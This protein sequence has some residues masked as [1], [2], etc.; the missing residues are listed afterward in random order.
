MS[1]THARTAPLGP[2][3][4]LLERLIGTLMEL[5]ELSAGISMAPKLRLVMRPILARMVRDLEAGHGALF[6]FRPQDRHFELLISEAAPDKAPRL[7]L[8]EALERYWSAEDA[9]PF[10][11]RSSGLSD[12]QRAFV[13]AHQAELVGFPQGL[14]IPLSVR[15]QVFGL[16]MLGDKTSGFPYSPLELNVLTVLARQIA[17]GL[18]NRAQQTEHALARTELLRY[19]E[20]LQTLHSSLKAS[21]IHD[22]LVKEAVALANARQGIMYI[23]DE[24][25][26]E[27]E[28]TQAFPSRSAAG[29]M[30]DRHPL[31]GHMLESVVRHRQPRLLSAGE[32]GGLDAGSA[33]AVPLLVRRG[34]SRDSAAD[35]DRAEM[36]VAGVLCVFDKEIGR[37]VGAF[38]DADLDALASIAVTGGAAVQN[39]RLYEQATRDG[40]TRL[41]IRHYFE[42]R[43]EDELNKAAQSGLPLA[44]LMIDI[45]KFKSFNDT[46]GHQTGD[47]VLRE[48]SQVLARNVRDDIDVP[49]RF[50]GEELLALLPETGIESATEIADRIRRAIAEHAV[51]DSAGSLLQVTVSVGVAVFPNHGRDSQSLVSAAD[52]ALYASKHDGRNRVTVYDPQLSTSHAI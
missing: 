11:P 40:L 26:D 18:Y 38:T 9:F 31:A 48:V 43:L 21:F 33:A 42:Q 20:Y 2:G 41:Y 7:P 3:F 16:A 46:Y 19:Q 44:L 28:L 37:S 32:L 8:P 25:A 14:W 17:G 5:G 49:A 27:L 52:L 6:E 29:R 51:P 4:A 50:G 1:S 10:E 45:D 34:S 22:V 24:R 30:G 12:L 15:G 13:A 47:Q 23:Y 36:G 39:A 35:A